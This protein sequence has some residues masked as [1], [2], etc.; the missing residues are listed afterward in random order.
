[1]TVARIAGLIQTKIG[2]ETGRGESRR[3]SFLL[4]SAGTV[5]ASEEV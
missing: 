4:Y 1:M 3:V 2:R 5:E